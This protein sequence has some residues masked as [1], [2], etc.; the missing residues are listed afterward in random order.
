MRYM[1]L[2]NL[3]LINLGLSLLGNNTETDVPASFTQTEFCL[4]T[5]HL[6]QQ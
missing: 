2:T 5:R 1:E 6:G 4:L 3:Q